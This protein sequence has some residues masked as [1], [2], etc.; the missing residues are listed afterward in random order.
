MLIG[1]FDVWKDSP[2]KEYK[3]LKSKLE[4]QV[5]NQFFESLMTKIQK[6]K[7]QLLVDDWRGRRS[8]ANFGKSTEIIRKNYRER[9]AVNFGLWPLS[10]RFE[11]GKRTFFLFLFVLFTLRSSSWSKLRRAM[12]QEANNPKIKKKSFY[13]LI[14]SFFPFSSLTICCFS[15]AFFLC[16]SPFTPFCSALSS[17]T[18]SPNNNNNN[19]INSNSNHLINDQC[20]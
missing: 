13:S 2:T 4:R 11:K 3:G 17:P 6:I 1:R 5:K 14:V 18:I 20:W 8:F 7:Q 12:R 15:F 19:N 10:L 16:I 9:L